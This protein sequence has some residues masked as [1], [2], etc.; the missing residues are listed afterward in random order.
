[1]RAS[2]RGAGQAGGVVPRSRRGRC[3]H[4]PAGRQ[5]AMSPVHELSSLDQ[6]IEGPGVYLLPAQM[7][8]GLKPERSEG[9][10]ERVPFA[11]ATEFP[12]LGEFIVRFPHYWQADARHEFWLGGEFNP[13]GIYWCKYDP[14]QVIRSGEG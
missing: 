13:Q 2:D 11:W 6:R 14:R 7:Q 12:P 5:C 3:H 1:A 9:N 8:F 4:R 10:R